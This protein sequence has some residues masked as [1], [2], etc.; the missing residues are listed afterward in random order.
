[1]GTNANGNLPAAEPIRPAPEGASSGLLVVCKTDGFV[2]FHDP[3]GSTKVAELKLPDFP[4]DVALAPDRKTAYASI[5]GNGIVGTNTRPG[6]QIAVID[7]GQRKLAGFIE[8]A[9][10]CAPHGMMFDRDGNLWST[11]ELADSVVVIDAANR[12]LVKRI[13]NF[14]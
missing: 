3:T 7:L 10:C 6:T 11:A 1:M 8:I 9:P 5:C 14:R 2:E 13:P 12:Q 4:H